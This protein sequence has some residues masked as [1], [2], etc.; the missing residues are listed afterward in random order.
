ML[1][2]SLM[3]HMN[4]AQNLRNGKVRNSD[5]WLFFWLRLADSTVS[6]HC[7]WCILSDPIRILVLEEYINDCIQYYDRSLSAQRVLVSVCSIFLVLTKYSNQ[8][9]KLTEQMHFIALT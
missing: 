7:Y 4:I 3:H 5:D 8:M 2:T 6:A 9:Q 1:D